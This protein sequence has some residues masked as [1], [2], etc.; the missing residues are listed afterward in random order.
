MDERVRVPA[1]QFRN[2]ARL[3]AFFRRC[4]LAHN[5]ELDSSS[6]H[7]DGLAC[8]GDVIQHFVQVGS[9]VRCTSA[10]TFNIAYVR[11]YVN[12]AL[13]CTTL[14]AERA[15]HKRLRSLR[16][17]PQ[18]LKLWLNAEQDE[19]AVSSQWSRL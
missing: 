1:D 7:V 8:L 9:E 5:A 17:W 13:W 15:A 2:H 11:T 19:H 14:Q 4:R 3:F 6:G 10:H 18:R 16:L 12:I